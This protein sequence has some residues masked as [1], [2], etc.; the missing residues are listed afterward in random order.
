VIDGLN[1][2][3]MITGMDHYHVADMINGND[4]TRW[5]V[6]I[7]AGEVPTKEELAEAKKK[8]D[9]TMAAILRDGDRLA[10]MG[11]AGVAAMDAQHRKAAAYLRQHREWAKKPDQMDVCPGCGEFVQPGVAKC[12]HCGSILN[13][14]VALSLDMVS[15]EQYDQHLEKVSKPAKA[16]K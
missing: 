5:G 8:L 16:K 10:A 11:P 4:R 14:D 3:K 7:A 2:C 12:K 6:F 9:A 13:W 1:I 15:Q